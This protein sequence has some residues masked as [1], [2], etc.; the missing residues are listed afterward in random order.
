MPAID[1]LAPG[2]APAITA[3]F[4]GLDSLRDHGIQRHQYVLNNISET[5]TS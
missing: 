2:M 3:G 1:R 4:G 5:R